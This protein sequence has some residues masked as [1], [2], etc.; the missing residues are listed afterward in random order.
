[1][2]LFRCGNIYLSSAP[3]PRDRRFPGATLALTL[4]NR[5]SPRLYIH[6]TVC[7][8]VQYG[9]YTVLY[10]RG[11][12]SSM[13][14]RYG[15]LLFIALYSII[16][17]PLLRCPC[18][19]GILYCTATGMILQTYSS[20]FDSAA[21]MLLGNFGKKNRMAT[22]HKTRPLFSSRYYGGGDLTPSDSA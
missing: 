22:R 11:R 19:A 13:R 16:G 15:L 7:S 3:T 8:I 1:M 10:Q 4:N 14:G 9:Y 20:R 5:P 18:Y 2:A 21:C 6:N 17:A 12:L